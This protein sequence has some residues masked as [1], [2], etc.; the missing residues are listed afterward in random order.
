LLPLAP[1]RAQQPDQRPEILAGQLALHLVV[2]PAAADNAVQGVQTAARP[3][4][5]VVQAEVAYG[6]GVAAVGTTADDQ[7]GRT[8]SRKA[9]RSLSSSRRSSLAQRRC[10]DRAEAVRFR[11][12]ASS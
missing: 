9:S 5:V 11:K 4:P 2:A 1:T 10:V 8:V 12:T 3:R 7:V 6:V